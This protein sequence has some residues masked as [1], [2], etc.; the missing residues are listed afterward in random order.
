M[1]ADGGIDA[2]SFLRPQCCLLFIDVP[3][4]RVTAVE[5]HVAGKQQNVRLLLANL[6]RQPLT[7]TWLCI[8]GIAGIGK[9]HVAVYHDAQWPPLG[10]VRNGKRRTALIV[11]AYRRRWGCL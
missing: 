7:H 9:P 5:R 6:V 2:Q 10:Q 1:I 11:D 8:G 3:V 4:G